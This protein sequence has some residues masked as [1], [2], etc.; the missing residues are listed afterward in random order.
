VALARQ[1]SVAAV[2]GRLG[3][4]LTA[5]A[6]CGMLAERMRLT[7]ERLALREFQGSDG[8]RV[9]A[10]ESD[11]ESV[12]Y[13]SFGPRTREESLDYARRH[14]MDQHRQE[15]DTWDLVVTLH[16]SDEMIGRCGLG[17]TGDEPGEAVLWYQFDR[18]VWGR[19]YATEAAHAVVDAGFTALGLHR[20]WA[21]C[22]PR[23]VGS[24]RV[25]EKVGF[26]PEGHLV[27]NAW[28]KGEWVDS[29]IYALLR[30]EWRP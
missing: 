5:A 30:R 18:A 4:G 25:L 21:D 10:I 23:H 15:R 17:L 11:P 26:R 7:T 27:E 13:Q 3:S 12:V 16:G 20:I 28:I 2:G 14:S 6:L 1:F 9:Y 19:G 22:D 29:L 24:I 8:E